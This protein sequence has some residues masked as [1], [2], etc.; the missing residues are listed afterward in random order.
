MKTFWVILVSVLL[1]VAL[2]LSGCSST[3][4]T[5]I[6][7]ASS[8]IPIAPSASTLPPAPPSPSI[9]APASPSGAATP[10]SGG[11][12]K[13][14]LNSGPGALG[15]VPDMGPGSQSSLHPCLE[16]LLHGDNKGNI[17]PW[18]AESYKVADDLKSIT[19]KLRQ[20]VKFHDGS[21][22]NAEVAKWNLDNM[23]SAHMFSS[24][25][26]VDI[27]DNYTI[28]VNFVAAA[29]GGPP[30]GGAPPGGGPAGGPS[31]MAPPS[32]GLPPDGPP[33]GSMPPIG[34]PPAGMS[35]APPSSGMPSGGA[36]ASVWNNT[37]LDTFGDYSTP[38]YMVS[39][40]AF[41]KNGKDWM[42]THPVGTGPFKFDSFQRDVNIKYVKNPDYW[43]KGKPYLDGLEFIFAG[44]PM[45][46]T[47]MIQA[48]EIDMAEIAGTKEA[49]DIAALGLTINRAV[50]AG[51][52]N[53]IPDTA[54]ASSPWSKKEFREAVEYALNKEAI[55]K[56]IGYG[57]LK[58]AYQ[59]P[60]AGNPAY[61]PNFTGARKYDPEKA[62]QLLAQAGYPDGVKTTLIIAPMGINKDITVAMQAD[63]AKVGIT[64]D[65]EYPDVGKFTSYIFGA[66]SNAAIMTAIP[67]EINYNLPFNFISFMFG[68]SWQRTPEF[69]QAVQASLA[70]PAA[71]AAL[72]QK[73][74]G[75]V[76]RDASLIPVYENFQ[77]WATQSYVMDTG[78]D[79]RAFSTGWNP[80]NIWLN[81]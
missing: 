41:D 13:I 68:Q 62:K 6:P 48:G 27:L 3:P 16:S 23:I 22:F 44:D 8:T 18:L 35:G 47:S 24:W 72:M 46:R 55:A 75:I 10:K 50:G 77:G 37:I 73:A 67:D 38:N 36:P 2:L 58:E 11:V 53:L 7:S 81:K 60:S 33:S 40:A 52:T 30:G 69:M 63:L 4:S 42:D 26:S 32:G 79:Q 61:D 74:I 56:A 43:Q 65:L 9:T 64:V 25:G 66:W 39:K 49:A 14:L 70:A 59:I 57:Y 20:G 17:Y 5:T 19:F 80:E 34:A 78:V 21:D 31:G 15:W 76:S 12:F 71:D 29:P 1:L 51:T 54:N 45:T 28:R